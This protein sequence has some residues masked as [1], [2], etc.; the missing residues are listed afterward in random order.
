MILTGCRR[1]EVL[2]AKWDDVDWERRQL[3]LHDSKTGGRPVPLSSVLTD[4]PRI[5]TYIVAGDSA[6][7]PN[8]GPLPHI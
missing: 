6:G 2:N 7:M 5:G 4:L 8:E 3:I 1:G